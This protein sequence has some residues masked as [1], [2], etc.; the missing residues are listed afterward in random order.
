MGSL[1]TGYDQTDLNLPGIVYY[2]FNHA[3]QNRT[4]PKLWLPFAGRAL[5][6]LMTTSQTAF[7]GV[8]ES[9][10]QKYEASVGKIVLS[11]FKALPD[12]T[13][14]NFSQASLQ[15]YVKWQRLCKPNLTGNFVYVAGSIAWASGTLIV[16]VNK[17]LPF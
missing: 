13:C 15:E 14:S 8:T 5:L 6:P 1:T 7:R 11:C 10:T 3:Y 9:L 16:N 2:T 4:K 17:L 12:N